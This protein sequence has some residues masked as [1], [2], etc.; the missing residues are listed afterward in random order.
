M[1][2][3]A[4]RGAEDMR[5]KVL[6][7]VLVC[8][9]LGFSAG[10]RQDGTAD[11]AKDMTGSGTSDIMKVTENG[12]GAEAESGGDSQQ[13]DGVKLYIS[14]GD[15]KFQSYDYS[16][17]EE[18]TP[19]SLVKA[20]E[21]LTGWEISLADEITTGK[22][23]MTVCITGQ[24]AVFM[25]PPANQ[26]E[27]FLVKNEQSMVYAVLDSIQKTLQTYASPKNPDSVDIYYSMEGNVP[28]RI[29]NLDITIPMDQPYTHEMLVKLF[30]NA[31]A[32]TGTGSTE[33]SGKVQGSKTYGQTD[34]AAARQS[35]D[36]QTDAQG[37]QMYQQQ[38]AADGQESY[39]QPGT[40]DGGA[41]E[42]PGFQAGEGENQQPGTPDGGAYGQPES[43]EGAEYGQPGTS[44]GAAYG[45]PGTSDSG[46]GQ[47]AAPDGDINGQDV[48]GPGDMEY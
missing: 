32:P 2:Y 25:G 9:I 24:S 1:R 3:I 23:G 44:E 33:T 19:D 13:S 47:I 26:K 17:S 45:Q 38:E 20:M 11:A 34:A 14:T 35:Y 18:A 7:L 15:G 48:T 31:D 28:I 5:K 42:Q 46:D 22:G 40:P 39:Q 37:G 21:T 41:Y 36:T 12:G 16:A 29:D 4:D 43:P 30:Q 10:C 8:G 6:L 27:D